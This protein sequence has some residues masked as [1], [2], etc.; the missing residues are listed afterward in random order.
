[1]GCH[2]P[3]RIE[4]AVLLLK[5]NARKFRSR[6]RRGFGHTHFSLD[7]DERSLHLKFLGKL[8]SRDTKPGRKNSGGSNRIIDLIGNRED[9]I[10]FDADCQF[11]LVAVVDDASRR[12]DL[13]GALLLT[14]GALP[15]IGGMNDMEKIEPRSDRRCPHCHDANQNVYSR[16]RIFHHCIFNMV[17]CS[18]RGQPAVAVEQAAPVAATEWSMADPYGDRKSTRLN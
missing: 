14:L 10:N 17:I 2:L 3:L 11:V 15:V 13:K 18:V 16:C 6:E 8:I 7:P 4:A 12:G 9:R 1:M 5:V